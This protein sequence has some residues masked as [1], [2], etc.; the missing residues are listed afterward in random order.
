MFRAAMRWLCFSVVCIGL[1][2]RCPAEEPHAIV[3]FAQPSGTIRPLHGVNGGPVIHGENTDLVAYHRDAGFPHTRLHDAHWP[4]PDVVD[5]STIFPLFHADADDPA[6]YV[7]DKTDDYIGPIV[8]NGGQVVFRLGESIEPW[9]RHRIDPPRDF[10]KWAKICVNIIR[11]YNDGWA[12][13]FHHNIRYWEVWNEPE[14]HMMWT[15]TR[16][17]YCSLYEETV[18]AIK[19]H[20]PSLKVGG[21]AATNYQSDLVLPFL[22]FCRDHELPL[23]FFSWHAYTASPQELSVEA[24]EIRRLLDQHGFEQTES[25][26]NEWRYWQTWSW[27]RPQD[28]AK[29][30]EVKQRFAESVG[31]EGA[32]F[33]AFVMLSMQDAPIDVMN[34]YAADTSPWSM[35][36]SY[37]IPSKTYFAFQAFHRLSQAPD[38]VMASGP[39]RHGVKLCAGLNGDRTRAVLLLAN[40]RAAGE[41]LLLRLDHLPWTGPSRMTLQWLDEARDLFSESQMIQLTD[42]YAMRLELPA[43]GVVLLSLDKQTPSE[44]P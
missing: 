5:I 7:F 41:P 27:L 26:L 28:S 16:E 32:G 10:R 36:D 11:H 33:A 43:N 2:C 15:G 9:T 44:L 35:F 29:Y 40:F 23:D 13:G 4:T 24:G 3:D 30:P 19:S 25:H 6:N 1:S 20:D 39:Y 21:P 22:Q 14:A 38:R 34:F 17:Q 8:A 18:R 37:G 42:A 12:K 31:S